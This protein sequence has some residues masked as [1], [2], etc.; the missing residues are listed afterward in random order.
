MTKV[1]LPT[2]NECGWIDKGEQGA[3]SP[4]WLTCEEHIHVTYYAVMDDNQEAESEEG[5]VL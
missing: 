4:V 2:R 3:F 1:F 5:R